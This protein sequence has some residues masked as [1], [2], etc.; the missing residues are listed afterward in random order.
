M[1]LFFPKNREER[2]RRE[3]LD[4]YPT[5]MEN[6][7]GFLLLKF[8]QTFFQRRHRHGPRVYEKNNQC[9]SLPGECQS[10]PQWDITAH[11]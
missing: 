4:F 5:Q 9:H 1:F 10:K 6:W 11:L 7:V 3:E 8:Q 2:H